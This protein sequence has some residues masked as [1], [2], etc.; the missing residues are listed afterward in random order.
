MAANVRAKGTDTDYSTNEIL[1]ATK[2]NILDVNAAQSV[3]RNSTTGGQK[4]L[5]V[6]YL[7]AA[8]DTNAANNIAVSYYDGAN[9]HSG[10]VCVMANNT[11][12][13]FAI[14]GLIAGHALHSVS[15]WLKPFTTVANQPETLPAIYV[16]EMSATNEIPT[17]L[18][19]AVYTWT[20]NTAYNAGFTLTTANIDQTVDPS[21]QYMIFIRS[22]ARTAGQG[23][24]YLGRIA[25]NVTVDVS[26]NGPDFT[27]WT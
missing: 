7:G 19:N 12:Q 21:H 15:V 22:S 8:Y 18:A 13:T 16:F 3:N 25:A 11:V 4:A 5:G 27:F 2:I 6:H 1:T 23:A 9:V 17:Q 24:M 10:P 26:Y 20:S 14:D